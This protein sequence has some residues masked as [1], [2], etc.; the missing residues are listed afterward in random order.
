MLN[1]GFENVKAQLKTVYLILNANSRAEAASTAIS[2][3]LI[4]P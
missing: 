2:L 3:G 4:Q 1:I